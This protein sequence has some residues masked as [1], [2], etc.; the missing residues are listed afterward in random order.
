MEVGH[1]QD[2]TAGSMQYEQ[3]QCE[4]AGCRL[5]PRLTARSLGQTLPGPY[6]RG[7][8]LVDLGPLEVGHVQEVGP[9]DAVLLSPTPRDGVLVGELLEVEPLHTHAV[10]AVDE[11]AGRTCA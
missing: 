9:G 3:Y 10:V 4:S 2:Y 7:P 8:A 1:T 5:H 11:L 6:R